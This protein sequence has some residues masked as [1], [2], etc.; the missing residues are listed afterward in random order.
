MTVLVMYRDPGPGH[1]AY[2]TGRVTVS[3]H[4]AAG[5]GVTDDQ[6]LLGAEDI[7]AQ[8]LF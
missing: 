4:A 6:I 7:R 2:R 3:P 1:H 5:P 8:Q